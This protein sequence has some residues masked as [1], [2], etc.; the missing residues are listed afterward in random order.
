MAGIRGS[1]VSGD[2]DWIPDLLEFAGDWNKFVDDVYARFCD[3][4]VRGQASYCGKRVGVRRHPE[5]RGKGHGFWHCVSEGGLEEER[6]PDLERCRRVGWIRA[7]IENTDKAEV[8]TWT[9]VRGSETCHLLWYRE[10]YLVVLVEREGYFMLRTAYRTDRPHTKR[11]LRAEADLA[12][13]G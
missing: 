5:S 8:E 4:L 10:E 1:P 3:D 6:T 2:C 13:N 11:K 12:K 7:V 9:N